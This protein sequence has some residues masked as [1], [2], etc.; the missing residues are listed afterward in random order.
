MIIS[1]E[2]S[3]LQIQHAQTQTK[4]HCRSRAVKI[5]GGG[6]ALCAF[7]RGNGSFMSTLIK[8]FWDGAPPTPL[9]VHTPR[10]A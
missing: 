5:E 6:P 9:A 8:P 7:L 4:K 2:G 10:T 3:A 1:P